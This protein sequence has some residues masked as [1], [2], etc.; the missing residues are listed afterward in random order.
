MSD[1]VSWAVTRERVET[2]RAQVMGWEGVLVRF[3]KAKG[4][5]V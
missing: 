4:A 5:A 1:A 3:A 2:L